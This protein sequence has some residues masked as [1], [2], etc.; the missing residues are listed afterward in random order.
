MTKRYLTLPNQSFLDLARVLRPNERRNEDERGL[1][2][3][4]YVQA[5]GEGRM[6]QLVIVPANEDVVR[7]AIRAL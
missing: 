2:L 7:E 6:Q 3:I 4:M 1:N 5:D